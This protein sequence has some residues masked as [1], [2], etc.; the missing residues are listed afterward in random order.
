MDAIRSGALGKLFRPDNIVF[1]QNGAGT[2]SFKNTL[3]FSHSLHSLSLTFR[4]KQLYNFVLIV[5]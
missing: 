1:G 3:T 2:E 5:R 4:N